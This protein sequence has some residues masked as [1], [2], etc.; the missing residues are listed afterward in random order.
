MA[1]LLL[2]TSWSCR[3]FL[4]RNLCTIPSLKLTV[5][6]WESVV[7]RW[8]MFF[9]SFWDSAY[10]Q[11][12]TVWFE[13]RV[14]AQHWYPKSRGLLLHVASINQDKVVMTQNIV[15]SIGLQKIIE[16]IQSYLSIGRSYPQYIEPYWGENGIR[17][18][19]G[20]GHHW[21]RKIRSCFPWPFVTRIHIYGSMTN[22]MGTLENLHS[23]VSCFSKI[24]MYST[25]IWPLVTG[26]HPVWHVCSGVNIGLHRVEKELVHVKRTLRI[27]CF[28]AQPVW[29]GHTF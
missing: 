20:S 10:F 25:I 23:L 15:V 16:L 27:L 14:L 2:E 19:L 8:F 7:G 12:P 17:M 1:W 11:G 18:N 29:R 4:N 5:S 9:I 22:K 21:K 26:N 6:P 24:P 3:D 28:N 13:G